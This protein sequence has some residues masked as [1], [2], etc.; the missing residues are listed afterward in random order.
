VRSP[1]RERGKGVLLKTDSAT[2]T[3]SATRTTALKALL[4]GYQGAIFVPGSD[5]SGE[6]TNRSLSG[7][8]AASEQFS[9]GGDLLH[10]ILNIN[11]F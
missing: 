10:F 9:N 7:M 4:I 2:Q 3:T 6:V 8:R 1:L 5:V 11:E